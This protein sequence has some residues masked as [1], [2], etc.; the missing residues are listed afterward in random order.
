MK[1]PAQ[2]T[3]SYA[4]SHKIVR[5]D[6]CFL[7]WLRVTQ[8]KAEQPLQDMELLEKSEGKDENQIVEL[9]RKNQKATGTY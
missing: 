6:V 8:C 7:V 9:I 2:T 3:C 4:Y 1:G 5:Q